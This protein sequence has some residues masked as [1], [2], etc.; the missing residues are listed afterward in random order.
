MSPAVTPLIYRQRYLPIPQ[1]SFRSSRRNHRTDSSPTPYRHHSRSQSPPSSPISSKSK[2][3]TNTP[4]TPN[5]QRQIPPPPTFS[6]PSPL[7]P[8]SDTLLKKRKRVAAYVELTPWIVKKRRTIARGQ[9]H[10]TE[11]LRASLMDC[12]PPK[13]HST[14][15]SPED[16]KPPTS[17]YLRGR[18]SFGDAMLTDRHRNAQIFQSPVPSP[19]QPI[20]IPSNGKN[21]SHRRRSTNTRSS[22]PVT[23]DAT[24]SK[25]W[26]KSRSSSVSTTEEIPPL[27]ERVITSARILSPFELS[28]L[29][30][31]QAAAE[32]SSPP[33]TVD[34]HS[35]AV[36][37]SGHHGN[38][39]IIVR[40]PSLQGI[41]MQASGEDSETDGMST[42]EFAALP[43][44]PRHRHRSSPHIVY[45]QSNGSG[46]N[47]GSASTSPTIPMFSTQDAVNQFHL[48]K[49]G[50][51]A[52]SRS[53]STSQSPVMSSDEFGMVA[54]VQPPPRP[55]RSE[56]RKPVVADQHAVTRAS[57]DRERSGRDGHHN[58]G[59]MPSTSASLPKEGTFGLSS[60]DGK[61]YGTFGN[62]RS[63]GFVE[64][65][66]TSRNSGSFW[67]EVKLSS[68]VQSGSPLKFREMGGGEGEKDRKMLAEKERAD[69]WDDLLE[70]SGRVGGTIHIG[71]T[72]LAP[73]SLRFSDHSTLTTLN[74]SEAW[75][76]IA[77]AYN[78][79]S[80]WN[81]GIEAAPTGYPS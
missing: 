16:S 42:S 74:Y 19:R 13:V 58:R 39:V 11:A 73:D 1:V 68:S 41:H 43:T 67:E 23:S 44:P 79:E 81:E 77:A 31:E 48:A 21:P 24:F 45:R 34:L 26:Q 55:R 4:L 47:V 59:V 66:K 33:S 6:C 12:P 32:L 2:S 36:S 25:Y 9:L 35:P 22:S 50:G 17:R 18:S 30:R 52:I 49:G 8:P 27:P 10:T 20:P 14:P 5:K 40:K 65:V 70:R 7:P 3:R 57:S 63:K 61:V 53:S 80:K 69:R 51:V 71:N 64:L 78:S 62:S 56:R 29:E 60:G 28:K 38:T 75:N 72:K 76:N 15:H 54:S 37:S 46:P